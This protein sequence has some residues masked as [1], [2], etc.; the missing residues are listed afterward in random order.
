MRQYFSYLYSDI[1]AEG[2]IV[3]IFPLIRLSVGK[4]V[5]SFL[6]MAT[7]LIIFSSDVYLSNHWSEI[8]G[9]WNIV[10]LEGWHLHHDFRPQGPCPSVGLG[11]KI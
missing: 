5:H 6:T 9:I 1:Y 8:T 11:V 4:F 2:Y 10:T 7:F 3:F